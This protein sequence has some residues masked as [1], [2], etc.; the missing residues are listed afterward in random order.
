M[1]TAPWDKSSWQKFPALQQPRWP[2]AESYQQA[3]GSLAELPPLVFAGEIRTLK[4]QLAEAVEG[5]AFVQHVGDCAEDFSRCTG[6]HI[7]ELLK[8]VLQM[9]VILAYGGEKR[10]I[11]IGRIAGQYAKPRSS[12][13]ELVDGREIPSYRGDMINSPEPTLAARTPDAR[14]LLEGYFRAAATLNLARAFTRGGY[15]ALDRVEAWH[16]QSLATLPAG[17]KY[18]QLAK[19]IRKTIKFMTAIGLATDSPLLNQVTMYTSHEAL[20]LGYEEALTRQDSITSDWYDC[21][22]HM[23]WIGDRTRQLDGAHIEFLRGVRNPLGLKVGPK[24]DLDD[25]LRIIDRLNP[26]NEPGRLTLITRFGAEKVNQF[27]PSL[28][29]AMRREGRKVVWSCDPMHGNT[30]QSEFGHKT[31][32][33][34]DI[35]TEIRNFFA[36]HRAEGTV[37]GGVH[38]ELTG[39]NVT[40]CTG[41]SRQLLDQ[42]LQQNYQTNCDPRLNAEQSVELAFELAEM[43]NPR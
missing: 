33:F 24:H 41:G 4:E 22:A 36:I 7:R 35:L 12:D 30:Y 42:H 18:E 15:A 25:I 3:V 21:S 39:E 37:P 28:A 11:K 20:L 6:A 38:L 19:Q 5:R 14:R 10:V 43:L 8:V 1:S 27:L 26:E 13:S 34:D 31:R 32:N 40:E 16:R 23:L 29:R 2:D 17:Q 9:S